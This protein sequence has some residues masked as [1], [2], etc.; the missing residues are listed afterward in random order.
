MGSQYKAFPP[1][2][3]DQE[4]HLP[5]FLISGYTEIDIS[6]NTSCFVLGIIDIEQLFWF[7][8]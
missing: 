1:N 5:L 6:G 4:L 3:G 7:V 8:Q 2:V